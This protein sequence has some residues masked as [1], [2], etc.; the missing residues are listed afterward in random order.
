MVGINMACA[1]VQYRA[2]VYCELD[3]ILTD[4]KRGIS[5]YVFCSHLTLT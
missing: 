1:M 4:E 2:V 3:N 5:W